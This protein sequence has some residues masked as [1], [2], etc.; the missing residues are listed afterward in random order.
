MTDTDTPDTEPRVALLLGQLDIAWALFEHH[1]EGIDDRAALWEPAPGAWSVRPGPGGA[2]T[3]DWQVPEPDPAPP[4]T[5]AWTMWHISYWWST[6][7]EVCF[8]GGR[9]PERTSITWPGSAQAAAG[10][11]RGLHAAWRTALEGA[12]A[13]DLDSADRTA[14]LPWPVEMT[15]GDAAGWVT[16]ELTKNVSEIGLLRHLYLNRPGQRPEASQGAGGERP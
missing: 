3:P 7:H 9:A 1:L 13:A 5:I 15:L 12:T 11:L 2:W 8:G 4:V 14:A 6:V 16:V 10:E